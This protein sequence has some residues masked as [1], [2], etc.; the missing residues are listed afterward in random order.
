VILADVRRVLYLERER[1]LETGDLDSLL[2]VRA[3]FFF[4]LFFFFSYSLSLS[5]SLDSATGLELFF[6]CRESAAD[7]Y[8]GSNIRCIF[9]IRV[10]NPNPDPDPGSESRM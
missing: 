10:K 9:P 1:S 7:P 3:R 2:G 4:F 5:L 8:P 6:K